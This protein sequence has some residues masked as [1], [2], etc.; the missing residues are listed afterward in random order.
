MLDESKAQRGWLADRSSAFLKDVLTAVGV[1]LESSKMT[2]ATMVDVIMLLGVEKMQA[3]SLV[4]VKAGGAAC[5]VLRVPA[6]PA[7]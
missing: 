7:T 5:R 6:V 3:L 4:D 2:K 1:R